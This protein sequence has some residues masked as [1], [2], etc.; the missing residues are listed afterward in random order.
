LRTDGEF[1][2]DPEIREFGELLID[3]EEVKAAR[4]WCSGDGRDGRKG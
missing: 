1:W 4:G 2:G 3:L